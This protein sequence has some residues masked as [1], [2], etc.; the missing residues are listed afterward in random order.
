MTTAD[1]KEAKYANPQLLR[2]TLQVIKASW[3]GIAD[4]L[5]GHMVSGVGRL[6]A[7]RQKAMDVGD[8]TH[9]LS[10]YPGGP[11]ALIGAASGRRA[12]VGGKASAA[13]AEV[14]L[15][16][17]NKGRRVGKIEPLR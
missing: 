11:S 9:K 17:Y 15:D 2:S 7:A 13:V 10:I 3:G 6:L 8:L 1:E 4:S 5:H 14:C 12:L 16:L